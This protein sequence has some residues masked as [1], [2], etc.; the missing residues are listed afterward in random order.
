MRRVAVLVHDSVPPPG[1]RQMSRNYFLKDD[2]DISLACLPGMLFLIILSNV[3]FRFIKIN[4]FAHSGTD[5]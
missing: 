3:M 4:K 2:L 1:I 5:V